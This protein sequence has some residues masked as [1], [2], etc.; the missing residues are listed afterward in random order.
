[1]LANLMYS[2]PSTKVAATPRLDLL[3]SLRRRG[4]CAPAGL[5]SPPPLLRNKSCWTAP[6]E[7]RSRT[8]WGWSSRG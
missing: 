3:C 4:A 1:V 2:S 6:P 5:T 8:R 7:R